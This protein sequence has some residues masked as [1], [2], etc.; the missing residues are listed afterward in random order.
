MGNFFVIELVNSLNIP[1]EYEIYFNAYKPA[2]KGPVTLVVQ[3]AYVRDKAHMPD[4][5]RAKLIK[6]VVILFNTLNNK[7]ILLPK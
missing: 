5:P 1:V 3:S 6:F 4:R 2:R 7:P